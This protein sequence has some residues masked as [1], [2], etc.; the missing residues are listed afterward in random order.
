M[1]E[2][3]G[4][5]GATVEAEQPSP[6]QLRRDIAQTREDLGDTAAA[7]AAK[8]DLK[9]RA[10]EKIEAVRHRLA[11]KSESSPVPVQV[12]TKARENPLVTAAGAAFLAGFLLGR[13][14]SH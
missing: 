13:Q 9:T 5:G 2:D 3:K 8:T 7:L 1:G 10:R 12:R 6:E 11:Q 14:R 4:K